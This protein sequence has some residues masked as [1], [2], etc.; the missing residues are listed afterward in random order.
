MQMP[1][2]FAT[3]GWGYLAS[4][5]LLTVGVASTCAWLHQALIDRLPFSI[6]RIYATLVVSG[7]GSVFGWCV[8][9]WRLLYGYDGHASLVLW[10]LAMVAL[11]L[12]FGFS[13]FKGASGLRTPRS[14]F[15]RTRNA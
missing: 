5:A 3:L 11:I 9:L 1:R 4:G 6:F 2:L 7:I 14:W 15:S 12:G 8:G 10:L 13:A